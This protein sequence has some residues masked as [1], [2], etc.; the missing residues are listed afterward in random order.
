[1]MDSEAPSASST[2]APRR[3]PTSPIRSATSTE[4][5]LNARAPSPNASAPVCACSAATS[6]AWVSSSVRRPQHISHGIGARRGALGR[7]GQ[8]A[9]ALKQDLADAARPIGR[10]LRG[11]LKILCL[12]A[13]SIGYGVR[14]QVRA[15]VRVLRNLGQLHGTPAHDRVHGLGP[16]HGL[17]RG[18]AQRLRLATKV[19]G[20]FRNPARRPVGRIDHP[21]KEPLDDAAVVPH[22]LAV[23]EDRDH[24]PHERERRDRRDNEV[25]PFVRKQ[26]PQVREGEASAD[27]DDR[28]AKPKNAGHGAGD[29]QPAVAD[30]MAEAGPD[31][32]CPRRGPDPAP[33]AGDH[34][35]PRPSRPPRRG[36]RPHDFPEPRPRSA[37]PARCRPNH[38]RANQ[39]RA[40]SHAARA[41]RGS[42]R[43]CAC[44]S[45]RVWQP[46]DAIV[47]HKRSISG[48]QT[49]SPHKI[50]GARGCVTRGLPRAGAVA[51][52]PLRTSAGRR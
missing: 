30:V 46:Q 25:A 41:L 39:F 51:P 44:P 12:A 49:R 45:S 52:P 38:F 11:R 5:V 42:L 27:Q 43:P 18:L 2:R 28:A 1:M 10:L 17:F 29:R 16:L 32:A 21:G 4:A 20:D 24:E 40:R 34:P 47:D 50:W 13:Q 19:L 9:R 7:R 36:R 22:S 33:K 48:R 6:E 14:A 3:S 37:R 15:Q 23:L 31:R 35:R 26:I 8:F